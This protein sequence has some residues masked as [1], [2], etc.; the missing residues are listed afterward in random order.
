MYLAGTFDVPGTDLKAA[1]DGGRADLSVSRGRAVLPGLLAEV[2]A[3][4]GTPGPINAAL[5]RLASE[6]RLLTNGGPCRWGTDPIPP[7]CSVSYGS[8][9]DFGLGTA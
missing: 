9:M 1:P 6:T 4:G 5:I 2:L 7:Y 3:A 8:D